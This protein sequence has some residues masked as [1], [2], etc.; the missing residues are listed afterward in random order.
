MKTLF[1]ALFLLSKWEQVY[2]LWVPLS[3]IL[4]YK[5]FR[6]LAVAAI[7]IQPDLPPALGFDHIEKEGKFITDHKIMRILS[8]VG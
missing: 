7:P 1:E 5:G 8:N 3:N 2:K 6:C 4:D